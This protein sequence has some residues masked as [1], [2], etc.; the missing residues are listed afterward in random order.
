[1]QYA[2]S[3]HQP[4]LT[5]EQAAEIRGV[6]LASGAK[7]MLLKDTGKKLTREGVPYYLAVTSA[8]CR[9]SSKQFKKTIN[10]KTFRFATPEEVHTVTGCLTGAVPPFGKIFDIPVFVD[11]SLGKNETINFNCGM[12]TK[13]ISMKYEDYFNV[14]GPTFQVFTEEEVELGDIPEAKEEKKVD[15]RDAK[16][17]E[18]LAQRQKKVEQEA[19]ATWDP[20]DPSAKLYGEKEPN[21][22]QGDPELRF[23]CHITEVKDIHDNMIGQKIKV[24]GRLHTTRGAGGLCFLVLRQRYFTVQGV[25]QVG[26]TV[27]KGMVNYA[28]K[29]PRESLIEMDAEVTKPDKPIESC[30]QTQV[31][32]KIS[33]FFI[34]NKSAPMLPFQIDDAS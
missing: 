10:C 2:V 27:S 32:L 13:S 3:E 24:R 18:R 4:V 16:K 28:R 1:V 11:R 6:S 31:E 25:L 23:K 30:T 12:R 26:D 33:S 5:S 9:F 14:E 21:K 15:N 7:A 22:S 17:A 34:L 20:N 8:A 29:T 19:E